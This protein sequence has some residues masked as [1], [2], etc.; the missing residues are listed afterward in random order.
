MEKEFLVTA[1]VFDKFD[2]TKQTLLIHDSF[3][4]LS[5]ED[6]K[7]LFKKKYSIDHSII[8]IYSAISVS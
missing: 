5:S 7:E 1:Q 4:T 3:K 8:K 6:A 2:K